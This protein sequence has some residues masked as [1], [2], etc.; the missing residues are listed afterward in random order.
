MDNYDAWKT[1]YNEGSQEDP[2]ID[3]KKSYEKVDSMFSEW[4]WDATPKDAYQEYMKEGASINL[5]DY[6]FILTLE[7]F[8]DCFEYKE[9]LD[10]LDDCYINFG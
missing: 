8:N 9:Y 4:K 10:T 7:E 3:C 1:G 2:R 6:G 5:A